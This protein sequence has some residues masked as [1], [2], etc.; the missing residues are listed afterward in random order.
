MISRR[1]FFKGASTAAGLAALASAVPRP[2]HGAGPAETS[3]AARGGTDPAGARYAPGEPGRDY[4]PVITPNGLSLPF[5]VV[6]GVKVFH[7]IAEPVNHEFAPGLKAQC[8]GFN[9][10]VHGPTIEAVEGDRL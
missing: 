3:T 7:L 5:R 2:A 1:H 10:R 8:W 4:T 9:G 6:D